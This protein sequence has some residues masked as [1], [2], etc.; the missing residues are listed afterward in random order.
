MSDVNNYANDLLLDF[1][2]AAHAELSRVLQNEFGANWIELGVRKHLK[3]DYFDRVSKMLHSPMRRVNMA[4]AEDEIF[5]IEHLW[6]IV[7]GNWPLFKEAFENKNR[8][9]VYLSEITELRNNLAH[10]KKRHVLLRSDLIRTIGSCQV[11]LSALRSSRAETFAEIVD[12]LSSGDTPW[13]AILE[14]Y[15]PPSDEMYA[16]F[17]GRPSELDGLSDWLASDSPQIL[18]WGYGGVGKSALAYKFAREIRDS[19]NEHLIAVCWVSAKNSEFSEGS[20]RDRPADFADLPS[21]VK[22]LWT[23]MYESN[24]VPCG[25]GPDRLLDELADMPILLVVDDFDTISEDVA[26]TEFLLYKLRGTSTRVIYTSRHRIPTLQNREVPPFSGNE[27]RDFVSRRAVD[28]SVDQSTCLKRLKGIKSVTG[29]YPLFVDDLIH[30]AAFVGI[31]GALKPE[32][33]EGM[34]SCREG[35]DEGRGKWM[36]RL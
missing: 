11:I 2:D 36:V 29:G 14:G 12:S 22:A 4:R 20:E 35:R 16:E 30:H 32:S 21:F 13:G 17:V 19:S 6:N 7:N 26:L 27:L 28:Y 15:L 24:E 18:V 25:L 23:A 33:T 34:W 8:T 31:D 10:R 3:P 5:G 9:Q 1:Y